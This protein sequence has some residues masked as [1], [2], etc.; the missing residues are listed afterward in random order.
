MVE[1]APNNPG[2]AKL[3]FELLGK[4][5]LEYVQ[6][7]LRLMADS[8][9]TMRTGGLFAIPAMHFSPRLSAH[10]KFDLSVNEKKKGLF[11]LIK[12]KRSESL[13]DFSIELGVAPTQKT[14][15]TPIPRVQG[16]WP[17]YLVSV[18]GQKLELKLIDNS[19]FKLEF[20]PDGD[21]KKTQADISDGH[22]LSFDKIPRSKVARIL[23]T[24]DA[25]VRQQSFASPGGLSQVSGGAYDGLITELVAGVDRLYSRL[26]P[27]LQGPAGT[28]RRLPP[29]KLPDAWRNTAS[30]IVVQRDRMAPAFHAHEVS[31][32]FDRLQARFKV[33]LD[34]QGKLATKPFQKGSQRYDIEASLVEDDGITALLLKLWIPDFLVSGPFYNSIFSGLKRQSALEGLESKLEG[35]WGPGALPSTGELMDFLSDAQTKGQ[36]TILRIHRGKDSTDRDLFLVNGM[37]RS[38]PVKMM[39]SANLVFENRDSL[40]EESVLDKV[41]K[42]TLIA[43]KNGNNAWREGNSNID[44]ILSYL[45]NVLLSQHRWRARFR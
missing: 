11:G 45:H 24:L 36:S 20:S 4:M 43:T 29:G 38:K 3:I 6:S 28:G 7:D 30:G 19:L 15:A 35:H 9:P 12:K 8:I 34:E 39:F 16:T 5:S 25:W 32:D 18:S 42:F 27:V 14:S 2:S 10:L 31:Y 40:D 23:L 33:S 26:V 13:A 1:Q 22:P 21:W 44:E 17:D 41:E 37:L